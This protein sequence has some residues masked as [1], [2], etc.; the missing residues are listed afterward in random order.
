M[1]S[2]QGWLF[3]LF[4]VGLFDD[5]AVI[6]LNPGRS[7]KDAPAVFENAPRIRTEQNIL[8]TQAPCALFLRKSP[9]FAAT[10]TGRNAYSAWRD[11]RCFDDND[12]TVWRDRRSA[13]WEDEFP[14]E[15]LPWVGH[16][17]DDKRR[18]HLHVPQEE[19]EGAV[20]V[21]PCG[22]G[23]RHLLLRDVGLFDERDLR[24]VQEF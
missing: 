6:R 23:L 8:R 11:V 16:P 13:K 21:K 19:H 3:L 15:A 1:V 7:K 2:R 24:R 4:P 14:A 22:G 10:A 9:C 20:D 5:P 12:D 17:P 18:F